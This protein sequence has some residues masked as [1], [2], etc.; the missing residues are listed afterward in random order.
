MI[1]E[2]STHLTPTPGWLLHLVLVF[3]IVSSDVPAQ[4]SDFRIDWRAVDFLCWMQDV[5]QSLWNR[6]PSRLN[7]YWKNDWD[8]ENQAKSLNSTACPYHQ[9]SFSALDPTTGLLSHQVLAIYMPVAVNSDALAQ[10]S[11]FRIERRQIVLLCWIQN[12]N[13]GLGRQ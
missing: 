1:S 3:V 4:A 11:D 12:S 10:A 6:I 5:N 8:I 7:A 9:W 13:H 2:H